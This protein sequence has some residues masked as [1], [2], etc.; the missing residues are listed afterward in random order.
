MVTT[1]YNSTS[2]ELDKSSREL[3]IDNE[4]S[5]WI[6]EFGEVVAKKLEGRVRAAMSDYE[7]LRSKRLMP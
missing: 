6:E 4:L 7:Y 3:N 2:I 1:L 5:K